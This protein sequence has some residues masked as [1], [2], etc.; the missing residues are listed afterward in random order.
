MKAPE[1]MPR[2]P[3]EKRRSR[4]IRAL[5]LAS[6]IALMLWNVSDTWYM[7]TFKKG[8]GEE[9]IDDRWEHTSL[10]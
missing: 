5:R 9:R 4:S 2:V 3:M 10:P 6:R 7:K 1:P 8:W